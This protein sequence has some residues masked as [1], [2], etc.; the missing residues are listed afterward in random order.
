MKT[1]IIKIFEA[2]ILL[3]IIFSLSSCA[4]V[5]N[6]RVLD[7]FVSR[8]NAQ[9]YS[10]AATYIYPGDHNQF[11]FF[12]RIKDYIA[13]HA[14]LEVEDSKT[15]ADSLFVSFKWVN[16]NDELRQYYENIGKPLTEND[17]LID[18]MM[19]RK[20]MDGR[21][22]SFNWVFPEIDTDNMRIASIS[23]ESVNKMN[24]RSAPN[25][26]A[27]IIGDLKKG[28]E[29]FV[30][31]LGGDW[32]ECY[33]LYPDQTLCV[34]Y[35]YTANMSLSDSSFFSLNI[36]DSMSLL[37]AFILIVV[38]AVP[39]FY[40]QGIAEAVSGGGCVGVGITIVL[41][42]GILYVLYQVL[43]KILFELFIIN[44]PY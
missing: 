26:N 32:S 11:A 29:I 38:I 2:L 16:A 21:T 30:S 13:P 41:L 37:V 9:E 14:F 44:L 5:R 42:L 27:K 24:I 25:K 33:Q 12:A 34:G 7:K 43:E 40:M 20:T 1:S 10:C 23:S 28:Q 8:Y 22:I 35:I 15:I 36:F 31:N 3:L 19:V 6:N 39:L 4:N 18:T 17:V